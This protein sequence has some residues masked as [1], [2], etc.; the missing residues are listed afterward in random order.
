MPKSINK[1]NS[2]ILIS[3]KSYKEKKLNPCA[4]INKHV[5]K[6]NPK[7]NIY[8]QSPYANNNSQYSYYL[9]NSDIYIDH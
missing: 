8:Y 1:N 2:F 9:K 4:E 3:E 7:N 6:Y 5:N